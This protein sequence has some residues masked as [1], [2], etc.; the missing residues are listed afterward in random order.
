M[1]ASTGTGAARPGPA[2][3]IDAE[4]AAVA[5]VDVQRRA[6]VPVTSSRGAGRRTPIAVGLAVLAL[7]LLVGVVGAY[8]FLPSAT[9][10]VT[11][12]TGP[13]GPSR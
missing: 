13:S 3:P 10:V 6:D 1:A 11:P 7:A 8:L 5:P 9:I 2:R 4:P 12:R